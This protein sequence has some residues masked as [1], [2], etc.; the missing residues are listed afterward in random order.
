VIF[1]DDFEWDALLDGLGRQWNVEQHGYNI[2]RYPAQIG[3]QWATEAV[4]LLREKNAV[5]PEEV[6]WLELEVASKRAAVSN[7]RPANGLAGKFS[8]EYC[9]AVALTQDHVGIDTFTDDRRFRE[10]MTALLGKIELTRDP[11][12]SR[13]TRNMRVEVTVTMRDGTTHKEVCAR[14]PGSWG[15]PIDQDAHRAKVRS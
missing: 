6:E 5:R 8:F 12:R 10:D 1:G 14:P 9:A 2:K 15:A 13:D 11:T 7:P 3:M 4:R